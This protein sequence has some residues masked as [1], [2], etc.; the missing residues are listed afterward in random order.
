MSSNIKITEEQR[1]LIPFYEDKWIKQLHTPLDKEETAEA[2]RKFYAAYNLKMPTIIYG[3]S[4]KECI[5][6]AKAGGRTEFDRLQIAKAEKE[7]FKKF[8]NKFEESYNSVDMPAR[9]ASEVS[10]GTYTSTWWGAWAAWYEFLHEVVGVVFDKQAY[11]DFIQIIKN[12][13]F[14]VVFDDVIYKNKI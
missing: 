5:A 8:K 1:K 4:P 12:I 9:S 11:D 13:H 10:N 14:S 2:V 3:R 6:M 7:D